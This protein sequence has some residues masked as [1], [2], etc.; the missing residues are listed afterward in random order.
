LPHSMVNPEIEFIPLRQFFGI[1]APEEKSPNAQYAFNWR[2]HLHLHCVGRGTLSSSYGGQSGRA[3]YHGSTVD[4]H[5]LVY[6]L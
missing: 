1:V 3:D 6:Q 2:I 4:Q 5:V